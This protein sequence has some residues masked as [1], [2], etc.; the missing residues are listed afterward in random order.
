MN[1]SRARS[2]SASLVL[3]VLVASVVAGCFNPFDPRVSGVGVT[4][5]P[6]LA[7]SPENT[8]RLLEWCYEHR[9]TAEYRELFSDDYRFVF[10]TLDPDG[11]AY[12]DNPWTREDEVESTTKLFQGGDA[13][14]PAATSITIALD[15]N[16]RV[17][18]DPR[19]PNS[20]RWRKLIRTAVTLR[21]NDVSGSQT[22]VSGYANFFLVRGDSALIPE[23]LSKRGFRPD[24]TRWYVNRHED[25]TIPPETGAP[26]GQASPV[27]GLASA[28]PAATT[29]AARWSWGRLKVAY[30]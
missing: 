3:A 16:F 7:D 21:I 10:G 8:L 20:V 6:P 2:R 17:G 19:Y 14:Q 11:L 12:R 27:P 30:R 24:S 13:N 1:S 28:R 26:G 23:E 5:P 4:E 9:A 29:W 25:D 15:R 18:I 22:D